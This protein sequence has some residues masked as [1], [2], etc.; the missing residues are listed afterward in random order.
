M[1]VEIS[2]IILIT[3]RFAAQVPVKLNACVLQGIIYS[4]LSNSEDN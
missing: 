1:R 4:V 2:S 3:A